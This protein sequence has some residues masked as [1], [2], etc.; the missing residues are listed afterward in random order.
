MAAF[1]E[2]VI[3]ERSEE[4]RANALEAQIQATLSGIDTQ[5]EELK[6]PWHHVRGHLYGFLVL[7]GIVALGAFILNFEPT[8]EGGYHW[9]KQQIERLTGNSIPAVPA[10]PP[11][12]KDQ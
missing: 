5:L 9:F 1:A 3:E 7:V 11:P 10:L 12:K 2:E 4:L 6:S 8:V